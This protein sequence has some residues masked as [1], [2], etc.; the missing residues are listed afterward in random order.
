MTKEHVEGAMQLCFNHEIDS[1][2]LLFQ[3][4]QNDETWK[5]FIEEPRDQGDAD[6]MDKVYRSLDKLIKD[7]EPAW[8]KCIWLN[9]LFMCSFLKFHLK[10]S[11]T[12][13]KLKD[14]VREVQKSDIRHTRDL[15]VCC[16][17]TDAERISKHPIKIGLLMKMKKA[18]LD[19]SQ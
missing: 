7:S 11:L 8:P 16:F 12:P 19:M 15:Y 9:P 14:L 17:D 2:A 5:C 6:A 1:L 18:F 3:I 13:E 4:M 10:G